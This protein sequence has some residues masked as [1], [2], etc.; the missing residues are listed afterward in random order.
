M[1]CRPCARTGKSMRTL[2]ARRGVLLAAVAVNAGKR[3][4]N[5]RKIVAFD[6]G[7]VD[8]QRGRI[9]STAAAREIFPREEANVC[10]AFGSISLPAYSTETR[11]ALN[12]AS[13]AFY[14]KECS[15]AATSRTCFEMRHAA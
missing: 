14:T 4:P 6:Q 13:A 12:A 11:P 1:P 10:A 5:S 2:R 3:V 8:E 7:D 15:R 9:A